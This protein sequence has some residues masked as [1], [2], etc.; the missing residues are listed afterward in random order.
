MN[1]EPNAAFWTDD[2][3]DREHASDGVSRF[4]HYVRDAG[5]LMEECWDGTWDDPQAR[6]V[7]FA[8][9]AWTTATPPVMSPGYVHRH[10]RIQAAHVEVN[11]WDGSLTGMAELVLPWPAAL[12][13]CRDWQRGQWW[14]D[15]PYESFGSTA[16][17]REPSEEETAGHRFLM[18]SGRLVFPLAADWLPAAPAGPDDDVEDTAREAIRALVAAMNAEI[19]PVIEALERS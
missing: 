19:T 15:W 7:R 5:R 14:R 6:K 3:Y 18:T 1:H 10:Q 16:W 11:Q 4:G 2:E 17:Y 12:S 9:A 13:K 8:E